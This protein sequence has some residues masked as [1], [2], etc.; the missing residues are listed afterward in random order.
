MT[1]ADRDRLVTLKKAKKKLITQ[2][3]AAEELG[4]STRHVKRLLQALK[5][6]GDK[7]V[8]HGLRGKPSNRRIP[9]ATEKEAVKTLSA[10]VYED[11][12]PTWAAQYLRKKHRIDASK[13][14]VRQW[15]I[16]GKLWRAKAEKVTKVHVWRPRRS[17]FGELVQW[18]TS[19]HDWLEGRGEDLYLIAMI[20][21]ATSRLWACFVRHDSTEENMK[22]LRSYL[23]R[24]GRPIAEHF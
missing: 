11:F 15:M 20:D 3:E 16:R 13:E 12:G 24:F 4:V 21:D 19:E 22:L 14:T 6:R 8:I 2:R 5:K 9:E 23:E 1:Q 18:D 10:E 7:A 17:R